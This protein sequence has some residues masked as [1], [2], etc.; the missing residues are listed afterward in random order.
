MTTVTG[1]SMRISKEFASLCHIDCPRCDS[2]NVRLT[3]DYSHDSTG[4]YVDIKC[5]NCVYSGDCGDGEFFIYKAT[6]D[7]E[8]FKTI[9]EWIEEHNDKGFYTIE[10]FREEYLS[11]LQ[12]ILTGGMT[13]WDLSEG[14]W[15]KLTESLEDADFRSAV[16]EASCN[17]TE[18]VVANYL[19]YKGL[20]EEDDMMNTS[21]SADAGIE[22]GHTAW[23]AVTI[24]YDKPYE[25][26][27]FHKIG[28]SLYVR[29]LYDDRQVWV[30]IDDIC[31]QVDKQLEGVKTV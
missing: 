19:A 4:F 1:H 8:H 6:F 30:F 25:H 29:G 3:G 12:A 9:D 18:F 31:Q 17:V 27:S 22:N 20:V 5:L 7:G 10:R 14:A 21:G 23:T 28:S 16:C 15:I 13:E 11:S 24:E 26:L 2:E